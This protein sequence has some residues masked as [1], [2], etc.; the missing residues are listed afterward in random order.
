MLRETGAKLLVP[1]TAEAGMPQGE[2]GAKGCVPTGVIVHAPPP[3]TSSGRTVGRRKGQ[4]VR[5]ADSGHNTNALPAQPT[6]VEA[7]GEGRPVVAQRGHC[8]DALS[9]TISALRDLQSTRRHCIKSISRCD[10]SMEAF[11][12]RANGYSNDLTDK[13]RKATFARAKQF[14]LAVEKDGGGQE[15]AA[16]QG[17]SPSAPIV[18]LILSSAA[19]RGVWDDQRK[20]VEKAMEALAKT[21]PVWP[22]VESVRGFGPKGLAV[23]IGEAGDLANYATHS[24]LWKRLGLAVIDGERQQ[25]KA[26]TEAAAAHGFAPQRRAEVWTIGDSLFRQQWA[27]DKD[28]DGKNPKDTDKPVAV[29]AHALGPYGE[30]YA[31][32]KA[33]TEDRDWTPG[34][35]DA[36]ARR[37]MTKALVRHLWQEWR[38][39][40]S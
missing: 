1:E 30:R 39:R 26:G 5:A 19:A 18:R 23:I 38:R 34:H 31:R 11:I 27:G 40:G 2:A 32:R 25:R 7:G 4:T 36:D 10:R 28:E 21:L 14:R 13:E 33:A 15:C 22:W 20:D 3:A 12:A 6:A 29:P 35:R 8:P 37:V 24:R 16:Q 17:Q 9:A